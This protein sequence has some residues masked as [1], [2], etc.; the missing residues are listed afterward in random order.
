MISSAIF[1]TSQKSIS[2]KAYPLLSCLMRSLF[3]RKV[4]SFKSALWES[5]LKL[6]NWFWECMW[7]NI[8]E[9]FYFGRCLYK[10]LKQLSKSLENYFTQPESLPSQQI[11]VPRTSPSNVPRT[12]HK[13]LFWSS[14]GP[15]DLT[16]CGRPEMTQQKM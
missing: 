7:R 13:D 12:S 9:Y 10:I 6:K 4:L 5:F 2:Q 14:R 3:S 16:S 8:T 11:L 15:P 1:L